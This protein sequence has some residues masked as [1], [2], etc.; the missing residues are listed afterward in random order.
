MKTLYLECGMGA[1]GD[2]L[3]AA[4]YEL[5]SEEQRRDFLETMN[6]L[7]LP[8]VEVTPVPAKTGGISGTHM[9]VTVHGHEEHEHHHGHN[10]HEHDRHHHHHHATPGHIGEIIDGLSMPQ[11]IKERARQVYDAIA[12]AEAQ[13]HG[14]PVGDV[15]YHEVGALDAVAD[16][17]GVC[18]A[19]PLLAPDLV[20][21]SPVHVGSGTVTCAHGIM[22][23]PAP[24]TAAL[25]K[26][27]PI[28]GGGIKGELCT[29]TGAALLKTFVQAFGP[30]AAMEVEKIGYGIG[31]KE[32]EQANCVRAFLGEEEPQNC[33]DILELVCN[34]DDMTPEAL[35][36]ACSRL[37]EEGALDVYTTPG[38][39]KKGR[40]GWV[41]TVLCEPDRDQE[42]IRH[43]FAH[44]STNGLR[45]RL[46]EKYFLRPGQGQVQTPWGPVR[47][48]VAQGFGVT[49]VKPEF[50]DVAALARE[51]GLPYQTVFECAIRNFEEK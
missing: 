32:F 16:V 19:M 36:F 5:L 29:P 49:H 2:M 38:T 43:I 13:A 42:M 47:V 1:A 26:G 31:T 23:V 15:H 48:K 11:E 25:L 50:E 44:T 10:G 21:A 46:S 51:H 6:G 4:L 33:G 9:R 17:A 18:Y 24:A 45:S 7:G 27:V 40:P 28:Y 22:P 34:I 3:M 35:A 37:L 30:M 8:G 12:Q 20:T 39:M 41:L 14:C